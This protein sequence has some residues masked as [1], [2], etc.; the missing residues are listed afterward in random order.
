MKAGFGGED[1]LTQP[2]GRFDVTGVVGQ[3]QCVARATG[4]GYLGIV[5]GDEY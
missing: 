1:V 3:Q 4:S 2:L 5:G